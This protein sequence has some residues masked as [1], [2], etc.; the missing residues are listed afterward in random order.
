[1]DIILNEVDCL[2]VFLIS[3][4]WNLPL[5]SFVWQIAIHTLVPEEMYHGLIFPLV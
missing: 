2:K 1:M 3:E 5:T 4:Y